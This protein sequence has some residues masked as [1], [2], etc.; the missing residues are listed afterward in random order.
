MGVPFSFKTGAIVGTYP[1]PMIIALF[2]E[3]GL[4][5]IPSRSVLEAQRSNKDIVQMDVAYE[6]IVWAAPA[7]LPTWKAKPESEQPK[8]LAFS[9]V[10]K[11]NNKLQQDFK[12]V[13]DSSAYTAFYH[14]TN[15]LY[16]SPTLPWKTGVLDSLSGFQENTL[17]H[18]AVFNPAM[19]DARV[20]AAQVGDKVKQLLNVWLSLPFHAV[21]TMH[22]Q[23]DKNELTG[24][25][26]EEPAIYSKLRN[27]VGKMFSQFYYASKQNGKP[28]VW[29]ADQAFVRG[30]GTRSVLPPI[31]PPDFTSLYGKELTK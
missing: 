13:G 7:D 31:C 30:L 10:D 9:F 15:A 29:T 16:G 5:I 12:V 19:A 1:K 18:Y 17:R 23:M 3:G 14:W 28:V 6:D 21:V 11:T 4:D 26:V 25:I 2:D 20:W 8:I 22:T 24:S 27:S